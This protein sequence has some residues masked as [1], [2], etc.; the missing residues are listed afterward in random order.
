MSHDLQSVGE[1]R[2]VTTR[3]A[4]GARAAA[5]GD[6][7]PGAKAPKESK[8]AA[9]ARKLLEAVVSHHPGAEDRP[10]QREMA[11]LVADV[12]ETRTPLVVQAG[13]GTGK[14][15]AYL[16]GVVGAGASVAI[17]TATKQL[18]DQLVV[19]DVPLVAAEAKKVLGRDI[20]ATTLKGRANYLC[21][22]KL[23]ELAA[24]EERAKVVAPEPES[25]LDLGIEPPPAEPVATPRK[26]TSADLVALQDVIAWSES[27]PPTGDRSD[28]PA[29]PDRAWLQVSTDSTSCPSARRC[30][31]GEDCFAELARE[32]ARSSDIVV[33]NHALL[34]ADFVSPNPILED[35]DVVVVDEVHELGD[36]LSSAWGAE[37]HAGS[38]ERV[39]LAAVRAVPKSDQTLGA[40]GQAVLADLGAVLSGLIQAPAQRWEADLPEYLGG[41]LT[42]LQRNC[43]SLGRGLDDLIKQAQGGASKDGTK[44]QIVRTGLSDLIDAIDMVR[45]NSADVVRWTANERDSD[46][47]V[48]RAAPLEVGEDFRTRLGE[49]ALVATS[50]TASV[51]GDF[52]PIAETLGVSDGEW[53]GV[54]VGSPFDFAK[55]GILYI[56]QDVPEPAGKDRKEHTAAVLDELVELT[57]AAGGRTLALFTTTVAA[58]NAAAHL[59]KHTKVTVLEHGE[60]PSADLAAEFAADETS[61]LCATMGLW[62][63]L[64]VV[65][66][67]CTLVVIDKLPFAPMDDP[68]LAARRAHV[69][70]R[71]G[72]GFTE[73]FVNE[74]ALMLTQGTGR[75]IRSQ[76]DRGVVAILDKRL[77]SRRYGKIMLASLPPMWR[78]SERDV[79]VAALKRLSEVADARQ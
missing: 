66:P 62:S 63:G 56:P 65:G 53:L 73:V 71:G 76:S 74:A 69:D 20:T 40:R 67:A 19:T 79:A 4:Q 12:V 51:A 52:T 31:F 58:Q 42:S 36:Y 6:P 35:R 77:L 61:I 55:Q 41:P 17:S 18:S 49:R 34:A 39:V 28:G 43:A 24:L 45:T 23:D 7:V 59:R 37:V 3:A 13:T 70:R 30:R 11:R 21:L 25:E 64:N 5:P 60:L 16:C 47:A 9:G 68:L 50:A 33:L 54:D 26:P 38:L 8:E 27:D 44:L 15:L 78:T 22:A 29:V 14:S 46:S 72:D 2:A 75:L 32:R 57:S 10:S 48:L 1:T